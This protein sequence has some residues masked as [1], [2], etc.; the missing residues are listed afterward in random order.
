MGKGRCIHFSYRKSCGAT[1]SFVRRDVIASQAIV[2]KLLTG[3]YNDK[4]VKVTFSHNSICQNV[5]DGGSSYDKAPKGSVA[6]ISLRGTML[7]YGTWILQLW[8]R[9][10]RQPNPGGYQSRN[11]AAIVWISTRGGACNAVAPR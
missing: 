8:H 1:G 5:S 9:R 2:Y 6:I 3:E 4:S 10:D 7:K 11:I